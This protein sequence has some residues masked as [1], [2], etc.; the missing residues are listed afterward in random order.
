MAVL[1]NSRDLV[2]VLIVGVL[3]TVLV[4]SGIGSGLLT[5]FT[6]HHAGRVAAA[7]AAT[8]IWLILFYPFL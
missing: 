6:Y 5:I 1:R 4:G 8:P 3:G 2:T 7:A